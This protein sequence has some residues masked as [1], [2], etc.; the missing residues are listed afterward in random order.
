VGGSRATVAS[1][2]TLANTALKRLDKPLAAAGPRNVKAAMTFE[3]THRPERRS[4]CALASR[5]EVE[6]L[7]GALA[8]DPRRE[9]DRC[10]Y[11]GSGHG[12]LTPVYVLKVRWTG[13]FGE[14]RQLNET[15]GRFTQDM[16]RSMGL[17]GDLKEGF[18]KSGA[19]GDLPANPAWDVAHYNIAGLSAV[20]KDVLVSIEPQGGT[21]DGA[22]KIM[23]AVMS[24]L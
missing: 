18:E 1:A 9:E 22:L 21:A 13:G 12:R 2:A 16:S 24:K 3:K 20:K 5:A 19:G 11:E 17:S 8:A 4:P 15:F 14:F 7:I 10:E 6:A 23:Q